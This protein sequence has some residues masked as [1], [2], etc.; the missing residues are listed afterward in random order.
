LLT[1]RGEQDG[2]AKGRPPYRRRTPRRSSPK[3][4]RIVTVDRAPNVNPDEKPPPLRLKGSLQ[5]LKR[6][7]PDWATFGVGTTDSM[8]FF[9]TKFTEMEHSLLRFT[10]LPGDDPVRQTVRKLS[11]G[12][13]T[14]MHHGRHPLSRG[15]RVRA[16]SNLW[17]WYAWRRVVGRPLLVE[18][19]TGAKVLCP[20]W[21]ALGG[22]CVSV[23]V[24]EPEVF[25]VASG[26]RAGEVFL[27][28]GANIGVYA[29]TAAR[30]GARV[31][32]FEPTEEARLSIEAN[33]ALNGVTELITTSA[34]ALS[35]HDGSAFFS[36][37]EE[38]GNHLVEV[39]SI[40]VPVEV[41]RIDTCIDSLL[42]TGSSIDWIKI[43]VEG[44]DEAV[45]RGAKE[46]L[47]RH[48]PTLIAEIWGGGHSIR[49]FLQE[50]GYGAYAYDWRRQLEP[51]PGE[52][53]GG[54][55]L[56][57]IHRERLAAVQD[58]LR[59]AAPSPLAAPAV[60]WSSGSGQNGQPADLR[61]RHG[62]TTAR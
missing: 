18:L 5:Q 27:D 12:L 45:L 50:L 44:G 33:A 42:G 43:D 25:L 49:T 57:A 26:V 58:R 13:W 36:V 4:S 16:M 41:R 53:R 17:A 31:V 28:V 19:Q 32:A 14:T 52:F 55:N 37:G 29:V 22:S 21:S 11:R 8:T 61:S 30:C 3:H 38:C 10:A 54:G 20:T 15:R 46:T 1:K 48:R 35:D 34:F 6:F 9:E 56:V 40:G 62:A 60:H 23:G 24:H 39:G 59:S 47:R 51:L 7:T 2:D